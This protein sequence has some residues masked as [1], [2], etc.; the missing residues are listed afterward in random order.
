MAIFN[1]L[2]A[3]TRKALNTVFE[4]NKD[5]S[6]VEFINKAVNKLNIIAKTIDE[7][8]KKK[9]I[10]IK[11]MSIDAREKGKEYLDKGKK[12][13]ES[14]KVKSIIN[15]TKET[16]VNLVS[17]LT[18]VF[19]DENNTGLSPPE[20]EAKESIVSKVT[21][22]LNK[23]LSAFR[24]QEDR[25]NK[26]KKEIEE[27]KKAV[28]E[29]S[30]KKEDKK[31]NWLG[32]ILSKIGSLGIFLAG[33]F[34]TGIGFLL[35]GI[36]NFAFPV[37]KKAAGWLGGFLFK[38]ITKI[39]PS[40]ST[41]LAKTLQ[42]TIGGLLKGGLSLGKNAVGILARGTL[43][44][45]KFLL[46][47]IG[48]AALGIATGPIG[49]VALAGT[50]IYS[51]YKLYKYINRGS[52]SDNIYGKFLKLRLLTYG[53][54]DSKK[55]Y[56]TKIF[57][58]EM[59]MKNYIVFKDYQVTFKPMS[60]NDKEKILDLF[61][62]NKENKE[63]Y[64]LLSNWLK[65]RFYPAFQ[66]HVKALYNVNNSIYFDEL[67]KL[68]E[69]DLFRVISSLVIPSRIYNFKQIPTLPNT[70][71]TVTKEEIDNLISDIAKELKEKIKNVDL[72]T[73]K[74]SNETVKSTLE[75]TNQPEPVKNSAEI[76]AQI[77]AINLRNHNIILGN[78]DKFIVN[79]FNIN[80][81]DIESE[82]ILKQLSNPILSKII[83]FRYM[84]YGFE[85]TRKDNYPKLA[86][87]ESLMLN[88]IVFKGNSR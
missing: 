72:N 33:A 49:W 36:K 16:G 21:E 12:Y 25:Q 13:L 42:S 27:E 23:S 50:T 51:G 35:K 76:K 59:L 67:N 62:I 2:L 43:S 44:A 65:N 88:Y 14:D 18:S 54:D 8:L 30:K 57:D 17:K 86:K 15:K 6:V 74:I 77:N 55:E 85:E 82:Q 73:V 63:E 29:K 31:N 41:A 34:K 69:Y 19:K 4:K 53:L 7:I 87:L 75:K 58:L 32:S 37:L 83:K 81:N 11:K 38:G 80:N 70:N 46:P 26:R 10:D 22:K 66:A 45:S 39:I 40:F 60:D 61:N 48:K 5:S 56:Y 84:L 71:I 78:I 47:T 3:E 68:K 52:I 9:N 79:I 1:D 20:K 64:S 28:A 24:Q